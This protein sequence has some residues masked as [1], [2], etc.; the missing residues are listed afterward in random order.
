M[1]I[2]TLI[3]RVALSVAAIIAAPAV[4]AVTAGQIDDFENGSNMGW[5]EGANSPNPPTNISTGG[6]QGANDNYLRDIS[7]GG[8]GAGGKM[9]MFNLSQ[10]TGDFN[11][12]GVESI[13]MWL[14]NEGNSS[15]QIRIALNGGTTW[16]SST[17]GFSLPADNM[18]RLATFN[19]VA[20]DM[21][22]VA[23]TSDLATVLD[24]VVEMRI[25]SANSPDFR[26][27]TI[28]ATL[29]VDDIEAIGVVMGPDPA[30]D[31]GVISVI[32]KLIL[33]ND[34]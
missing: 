14:R 18:W 27:A 2:I 25:L 10:W 28:A 24:S 22:R 26:G 7:A 33:D 9:V 32:L 31:F 17:N 15:M 11:A 12:A 3:L 21:T 19:L 34:P 30:A 1:K 13:Q 8:A 20:S 5:R 16:F 6:P 29:G 23:G 4:L